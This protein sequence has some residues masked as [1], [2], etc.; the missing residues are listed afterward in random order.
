MSWWDFSWRVYFI[1]VTFPSWQLVSDTNAGRALKPEWHTARPEIQNMYATVAE[2]HSFK[3]SFFFAIMRNKLICCWHQFIAM[4][5]ITLI[6]INYLSQHSLNLLSHRMT[7]ETNMVDVSFFKYV[8]SVKVSRVYDMWSIYW[9]K[10]KIENSS[11]AQ[12][13]PHSIKIIYNS[14]RNS[15]RNIDRYSFLSMLSF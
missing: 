7:F 2:K 15:F 9:N 14:F 10:I 5:L 3:R 13:A 4:K 1:V 6:V 8:F 12:F 11:C